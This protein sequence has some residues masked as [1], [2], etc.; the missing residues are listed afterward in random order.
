MCS[1]KDAQTD[2][3]ALYYEPMPTAVG[4]L[5]EAMAA[6]LRIHKL[7]LMDTKEVIDRVR[8]DVER[9]IGERATLTQVRC[10]QDQVWTV[11]RT[12]DIATTLQRRPC[13]PPRRKWWT[14][15]SEAQR[16]T[17]PFVSRVQLEA[18]QTCGFLLLAL[19]LSNTHSKGCGTA[20]RRKLC[21]IIRID[22]LS[23]FAGIIVSVGKA[24]VAHRWHSPVSFGGMHPK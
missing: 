23:L 12:N 18:V 3:I 9:L 24:I 11:L 16:D 5:P 20:T 7:I 22:R 2:K 10:G 14:P 19:K 15:Q 17:L 21:S 8:P 13:V 1:K 6:G 4:P